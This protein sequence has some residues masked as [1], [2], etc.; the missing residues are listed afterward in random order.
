MENII[1]KDTNKL[2][3]K[4]LTSNED[5]P[6]SQNKW[7]SLYPNI[8]FNCK[9]ICG[10]TFKCTKDSYIQWIQTKL[11]HRFSP[12]YSLLQKVS[13]K[14]SNIC[15]FCN[16]REE[17]LLHLFYECEKV[18]P[19]IHNLISMVREIDPLIQNK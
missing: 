5:T 16:K 15:S 3:Y 4:T 12:T 2:I 7:K 11:G 14:P 10:N 9:E 19:I 1:N 18:K 6:T 8:H 13:L 17:P